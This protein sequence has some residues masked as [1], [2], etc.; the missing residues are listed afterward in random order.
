MKRAIFCVS[1][2]IKA[3]QEQ[4]SVLQN[5]INVGEEN[6]KGWL[7][8][9]VDKSNADTS[10]QTWGGMF[11]LF[12]FLFSLICCCVFHC[13]PVYSKADTLLNEIS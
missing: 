12:F 10:T 9:R 6:S 1:A 5:S 11:L 8:I 7:G 3:S 4:I 13:W 2:F